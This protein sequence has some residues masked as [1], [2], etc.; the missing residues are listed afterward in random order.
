M[1]PDI[2][3]FRLL[4]EART[5]HC[6]HADQTRQILAEF[7]I[8]L[9]AEFRNV[10]HDEIRALRNVM[11]DVDAVKPIEEQLAHMRVFCLQC[12][13]VIV[14]E[15]QPD[16]SRLLQRMRRADRQEV[17]DFLHGFNNFRRGNDVTKPPAG[18]G[19][20]FGQR[21]TKNRAFRHTRQRGNMCVLVRHIEDM[22]IH[23]VGDD[24]RVVFDR[25]IGND[26]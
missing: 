1:E 24:E 9:V 20:G 13:I 18:D 17:V 5:R 23:L 25:K 10:Q 3:V 14:A 8:V 16:H 19:I 12:G 26:L 6:T 11:R 22:L 21:G 15:I 7:Q 4:E 2:A